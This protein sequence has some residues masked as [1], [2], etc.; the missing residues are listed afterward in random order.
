MHTVECHS[1]ES[2]KGLN[3]EESV[4]RAKE[5]ITGA[6]SAMLNLGAG[7]GPINHAFDIRSR[8]SEDPAV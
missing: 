2:R 3:L 6:L 7:S 5:Y 4:G 1:R 8:F